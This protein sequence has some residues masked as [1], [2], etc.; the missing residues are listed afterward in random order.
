[1]MQKLSEP[2]IDDAICLVNLGLDVCKDSVSTV[3]NIALRIAFQKEVTKQPC[4]NT[5]KNVTDINSKWR[6]QKIHSEQEFSILKP[7]TAK[8]RHKSNSFYQNGI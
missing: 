2:P 4:E 8:D 3:K 7:C 1:M 6:L 5:G